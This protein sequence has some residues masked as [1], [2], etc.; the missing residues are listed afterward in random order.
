ML[1]EVI[2]LGISPV[3]AWPDAQRHHQRL[4]RRPLQDRHPADL[5]GQHE[6]ELVITSY[7]IH[8]TKLYETPKK[9]NSA[10]RKVARVR[11]SNKQEVTAYIPGEGHEIGEHAISYNFV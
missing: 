7:S 6:L 4:A 10:L 3:R 5:H 1:Y 2:T 11:L 8:Y 9:P